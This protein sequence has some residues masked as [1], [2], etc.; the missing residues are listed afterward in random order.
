MY[1]TGILTCPLKLLTGY[2]CP[3]CGCTRAIRE[4]LCGNFEGYFMY[5]PMAIPLTAAGILCFHLKLLKGR[6]KTVALVF[7]ITAAIANLLLYIA[8]EFI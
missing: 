6:K 2:N 4:L 7:V 3:T 5:Q 8:R 1:Y